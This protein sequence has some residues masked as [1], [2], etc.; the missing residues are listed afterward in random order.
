V[1]AFS[2]MIGL[3]VRAADLRDSA[4]RARIEAFV[5]AQPDAEPFH[6]PAWSLGV[7]RGCGQRAHYLLAE[8]GQGIRGVLPLTEVRS[9]LFGS[10]LVSTGFGVG[11]GTL[12][13]ASDMLAEAAV[14]LARRIGVTSLELRGGPVPTGWQARRAAMPALLAR[15]RSATRAF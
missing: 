10:A 1:N 4:E 5:G 14:D 2:P 13:D 9:P 15:C 3:A 7:E 6:R 11:G 12:G 8:D